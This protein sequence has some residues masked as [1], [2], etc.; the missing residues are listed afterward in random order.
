MGSH[1]SKHSTC[2]I[3]GIKLPSKWPPIPDNIGKLRQI[4]TIDGRIQHIK[5]EGEI[6]RPQNNCDNKIIVLQKIRFVEEERIE[7]RFAYYM[8]GVKPR[9]RGKWIWGQFCLM[10]PKDDLKVLL[11][12]AKKRKWF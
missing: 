11:R 5:I 10:I 7:F 3:A 9:A 2:K 12:E 8:I 1:R 6:I 4:K